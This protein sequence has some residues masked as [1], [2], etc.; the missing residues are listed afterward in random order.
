M[1][2]IF[3]RKIKDRMFEIEGIIFYAEN[4]IEALNKYLRKRKVLQDEI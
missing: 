1:R 3:I 2:A 4:K